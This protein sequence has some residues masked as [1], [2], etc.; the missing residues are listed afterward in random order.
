MTIKVSESVRAK[1]GVICPDLCSGPFS[2]IAEDS[3]T[4]GIYI[5]SSKFYNRYIYAKPL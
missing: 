1:M 4:D 2:D 5:Q 3:A